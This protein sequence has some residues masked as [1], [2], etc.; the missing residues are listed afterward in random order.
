MKDGPKNNLNDLL[1][2]HTLFQALKLPTWTKEILR[3]SASAIHKLGC[4]HYLILLFLKHFITD[5]TTT[6]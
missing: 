5:L 1:F 2:V 6:V 4:Y 3:Y